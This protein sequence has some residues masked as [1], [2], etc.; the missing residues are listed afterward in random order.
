VCIQEVWWLDI[1]SGKRILAKKTGSHVTLPKLTRKKG[2]KNLIFREEWY[3]QALQTDILRV[4]LRN[5]LRK[6][7][8]YRQAKP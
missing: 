4:E 6:I 7:A 2:F 3:G 8:V 5:L 1:V